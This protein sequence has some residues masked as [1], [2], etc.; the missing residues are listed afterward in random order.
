MRFWAGSRRAVATCPGSCRPLGQ[1]RAL[2]TW[3]WMQ[4]AGNRPHTANGRLT[5]T[6]IWVTPL[7]LSCPPGGSRRGAL[8]P[9]KPPGGTL[10]AALHTSVLCDMGQTQPG[11]SLRGLSAPV[12]TASLWGEGRLWVWAVADTPTSTRPPPGR[13][14]RNTR[15][16]EALG[17]ALPLPRKFGSI[18][19]TWP[20]GVSPSKGTVFCFITFGSGTSCHVDVH[21]SVV[22]LI[23][24]TV[25]VHESVSPP[26]RGG[27]GPLTLAPTWHSQRGLN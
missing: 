14:A 16:V 13:D 22:L 10:P 21:G 6:I 4:V 26:D 20:G 9:I 17:P 27:H 24:H 23:D 19:G 5:G 3:E 25:I 2:L 12:G 11:S 18:S 7:P 1:R 8:C 15:P